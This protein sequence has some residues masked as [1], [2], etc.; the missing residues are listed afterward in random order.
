MVHDLAYNV[1]TSFSTA[2]NNNTKYNCITVTVFRTFH[3]QKCASREINLPRLLDYIL[4]QLD[5]GT[6]VRASL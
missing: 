5:V 6:V 3:L 2:D 1:S 4:E